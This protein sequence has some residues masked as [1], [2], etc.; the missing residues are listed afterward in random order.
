MSEKRVQKFHTDDWWNLLHPIRS[1]TQIWVVMCHQYAISVLIS[2]TSFHRKTVGVSRNVVCF[3]RPLLK[4]LCHKDVT[5]SGQFCTQVITWYLYPHTKCSCRVM[6]KISNKFFHGGLTLILISFGEFSNFNLC[7]FF[8]SIATDNRK[9]FQCLTIVLALVVQMLDS[10]IHRKDHYPV[11][12]Y[13]GNQNCVI[14]ST[15]QVATTMLPWCLKF[16]SWQ[17]DL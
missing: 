9:Q 13:Y 17:L 8:P 5:F 2:Q 6:E 11:D 14:H 4:G 10:T 7:L 3:L 16:W 12:K 15:L 1:T